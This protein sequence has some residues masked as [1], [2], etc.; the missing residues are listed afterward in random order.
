MALSFPVLIP[1]A[2]V[3]LPAHFLFDVLAYY[4][5]F[6]LFLMLRKKR[7]DPIEP[8]NRQAIIVG[9]IG[10]ALAGSTLLG[11]IEHWSS[12]LNPPS[13]LYYLQNKTI[14][15]G[16]LGGLV[17]VELTKKLIG[18]TR[19]SGD[20][21]ALPLCV[22]I[23]VGRIGCFLTGVSDKTA[24]SPTTLPWGLEQGDGIARHPAALYE[25]AF[26]ALLG[27]VLSRLGPRLSRFPGASFRLFLSCYCL[28]RFGADFLKDREAVLFG[29]SPIQLSCLG[30]LAL[31]ASVM[32]RSPAALEDR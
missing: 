9:A 5:G 17:G 7:S 11:A 3:P 13:L 29:L 31:Y 19:S 10:G 16:L 6:A 27:I 28:F 24:G 8:V 22:G 4:V 26:L 1:I 18:E 21:F 32:R 30:C 14:V 12:F 20:L 23:A 2:G 25:I 15:G